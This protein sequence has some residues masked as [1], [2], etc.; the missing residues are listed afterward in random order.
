MK[1]QTREALKLR[2]EPD[3][4]QRDRR[5]QGVKDSG[6]INWSDR[7]TQTEWR[8]NFKVKQE[9][10]KPQTQT[11]TNVK[12]KTDINESKVFLWSSLWEE[13]CAGAARGRFCHRNKLDCLEEDK[14][15]LMTVIKSTY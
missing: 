14:L 6:V 5:K 4:G 8:R 11:M 10:T 9:I 3:A 15:G 1:V 2:Q 12:I 7:W 13:F